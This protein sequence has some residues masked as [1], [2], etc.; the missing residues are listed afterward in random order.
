MLMPKMRNSSIFV[1]VVFGAAMVGWFM[2]D[3]ELDQTQQIGGVEELGRVNGRPV[4]YQ[5]Y[6]E[7]YRRMHDEY[8]Q[9][10][11]TTLS[12]SQLREVERAAWDQV[13][14]EMLIA[15]E[16][17]R[18]GI[19]VRDAEVRQA[20]MMYP[21]PELMQSELFRTNGQF[22]MQRYVEFITGP[23]APDDVLLQVEAYFR[24]MI[25]RNKLVRQITAGAYLTDAELWRAWRD[26]NET[27]TVDYVALDPARLVT[28]EITV[29]DADVRRYYRDNRQEFR[30]PASLRADVAFLSM[31]VTAEDSAAVRERAMQIRAEIQEEEN[32]AE[33]A[34]RESVDPGSRDR[35]GELGTFQRGDMVEAFDEAVFSLPIG[36]VSEPVQTQFG[37]H[38]IE[39]LERSDDEARA[40]HILLPVEASEEALDRMYDRADELERRAATQGLRAAAESLDAQFRPGVRVTESAP[41]APGVGS[42]LEA[43]EWAKGEAEEDEELLREPSPLFESDQALYVVEVQEFEEAG[44][45]TLEEAAPEIRRELIR[46]RQRERTREIGAEMVA[47]V[48]EGRSLE[49]VAAERDLEVRNTEPFT[50]AEPNRHL[51]QGNAAVGA[52]FGT[53]INQISDVVSTPTGIFIIRPVE[54]TE[55]DREAWE[56]Q[57]EN[58]RAIMQGQL[59]QEMIGRWLE[60]LRRNADIVDRRDQVL[61]RRV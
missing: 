28:E 19:R 30:R 18:R 50:R 15:E 20:A 3:F 39:V 53:P 10:L 16:V 14:N 7:A 61:E 12:A 24:Q 49:E 29:S 36:E 22:D 55:A 34:R 52:A 37:Y 33:V 44:T 4:S 23:T 25:P 11:G 31:E 42:L 54:R 41:F 27:A 56:A 17:R 40:R 21:H 35:G 26:R 9:Q 45:L 46:Q 57:K 1:A 13:V 2:M 43:I 58:Q 60:D 5:D 32:F 59:G 51:G 6:N 48:R 38:L 47:A 8:R